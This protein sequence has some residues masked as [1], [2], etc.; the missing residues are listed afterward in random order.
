MGM[1][2]SAMLSRFVYWLYRETGLYI[3]PSPLRVKAVICSLYGSPYGF[4]HGLVLS[5]EF[6]RY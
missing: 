5:L 2:I 3:H 6:N 1:V 4:H